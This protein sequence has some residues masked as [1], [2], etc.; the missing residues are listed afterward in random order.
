MNLGGD[1]GG[2]GMK[3]N[4]RIWILALAVGLLMSGCKREE[5]TGDVQ[6]YYQNTEGTGL[7]TEGY[8]WKTKETASQIDEMLE[9]LKKPEDTVECTSVIPEDV[10]IAGYQL[11]KN[12][13]DISF[14]QEY[15]LL[16][17][18]A[19]VLLRAAVVKSLTQIDG[20]QY[21]RFHVNGELLKDGHGNPIGYMQ[22]EDFAQNTGAALNSYQREDVTLYYA[23][24]AD[25][26]L[27]KL[28]VSLRYNSYMTIEK[29]IIE[30]L[31]EEPD[32]SGAQTAIP[33]ETKLLSVSVKDN[34]CYVN[35]N[36]GFLAELPQIRPEQTVYSLV[37]SI[38]EGG[39]CKQVQISVNGDTNIQFRG[40]IDLSKPFEKNMEIVEK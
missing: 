16:D 13:L 7:V 19:E 30:Q 22:S 17:K 24:A 32:E 18:P 36:E 38:I 29:A 10:L 39:N 14:S 8:E 26:N 11:D 21:V 31:M 15:V 25:T 9:R 2:V 4:Y 33:A 6:I 12:N 40:E 3:R 20:V 1:L 34:I 35:L 27:V 5:H 28:Q 37:N 23:N